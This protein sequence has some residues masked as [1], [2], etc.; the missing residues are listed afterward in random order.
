MKSLILITEQPGRGL[1]FQGETGDLS[2]R[3]IQL[4]GYV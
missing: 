4:R 1:L 3:I 2:G